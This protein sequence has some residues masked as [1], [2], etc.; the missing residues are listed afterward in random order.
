MYIYFRPRNVDSANF[1][2]LL[3]ESTVAS[4]GIALTGVQPDQIGK[5][6]VSSQ[7]RRGFT[8]IRLSDA[9]SVDFGMGIIPLGQRPFRPFQVQKSDL[10]A[11]DNDRTELHSGQQD[12]V[13]GLTVTDD[14]QALFITATVD[15]SPAVDL[16]LLP[17]TQADALRAKYVR[18]PGAAMLSSAPF[19][20]VIHAGTP[21]RQYIAV[22]R[23]TY[24][25]VFDNSANA[26][27]AAPPKVALDDRAARIDYLVQ[28]GDRP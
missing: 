28:V 5:D 3:V 20:A 18:E 22:P 25:L 9:G 7:L 11:L 23:G 10:V 17:E 26:G 27:V 13:S 2:T 15:G 19:G 12:Y 21:L 14:H 8:V 24:A 6:I 16:L 4:A 1:S